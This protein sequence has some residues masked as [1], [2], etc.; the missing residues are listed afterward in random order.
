MKKAIIGKK[1]GMTQV[2]LKD[3]RVA[4]VTVVQA[5][6]CVVVQKKTLERDG[7]E[8]L[9]VG[10]GNMP[11][12]RAQKLVNKPETGHFKK[13]GVA[14]MRYLRELRL[15]DCAQHDVGSEIRVSVFNEGDRIDVI[16]T[17]KGKGFQGAI[18]RWGLHRGPMAHGSKYHRGQGSLSANS[19]PSR[20]FK[21]KKMA[22][23]GGSER[24]TI[25]NLEV[26]SVLEDRDLLLIR[27]ALP[28]PDGG[29]LFIRDA[30]KANRG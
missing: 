26:V 11:E 2:F 18:A 22:G 23:H 20:V 15:D 5:G 1:I 3:G 30:V 10:Y 25:Q 12:A 17:S 24:V 29:V 16:G 28:G 6:P 13:S 4:P 27:G 9:Q 19:D 8:A 7:Y 14:P 21:N